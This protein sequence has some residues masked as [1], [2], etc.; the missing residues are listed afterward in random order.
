MTTASLQAP[1]GTGRRTAPAIWRQAIGEGRTAPAYL[2]EEGS[3]WREVPWEE[4]AA[5]VDA[6]ARGLLA[7]GVRR[8]DAVAVLS[9]TRLEWAL[10]DWAIMSIGAVV[11]GLYPTSSAKEC[12]Y[13]LE[14]SGAVGIFVEDDEQQAKI[15]EVRDALPQLREVV[16]LSELSALEDE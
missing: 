11:V 7:R 13:I 14:H 5:R 6:L 9:R 4:A 8:G 3:E 16:A 10:L 1:A 15:A 12:A 2:A